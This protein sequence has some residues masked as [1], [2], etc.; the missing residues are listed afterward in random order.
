MAAICVIKATF[1]MLH[2]FSVCQ[3]PKSILTV[4]CFHFQLSAEKKSS[5]LLPL[6]LLEM[7]QNV[8]IGE[9]NGW[10][11]N[12]KNIFDY[13]PDP[14][15]HLILSRG[16]AWAEKAEASSCL[17]DLTSVSCSLPITE[18]QSLEWKMWINQLNVN[19]AVTHTH[20]Q[21]K[22]VENQRWQKPPSGCDSASLRQRLLSSSK[23]TQACCIS[24]H[25]L[26][27]D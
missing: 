13:T 26:A 1:S 24:A 7:L 12:N 18:L 2:Y 23:S 25:C 17:W 15:S 19:R 14:P 3:I 16:L 10:N 9:Q 11:L 20:V 21:R 5:V 27:A 8:T 22:S 4:S 6:F